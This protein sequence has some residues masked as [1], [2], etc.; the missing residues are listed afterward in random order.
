M[1]I[2][3]ANWKMNG[4]ERLCD[5]IID[6]S[7]NR[8]NKSAIVVCPPSPLLFKFN[9]CNFSLGAQNCGHKASGAFT[10]EIS[11]QL[12]RTIGCSHVILGHSERR[13]L[14]GETDERIFE[15][16]LAAIAAN[17]TPIICIGENSQEDYRV[18]LNNQISKFLSDQN[19]SQAIF[20]YEPIWSIGTGVIPSIEKISE[21]TSFVKNLTGTKVIYGGSVNDENISEILKISSLDGVLVGGASLK[22]KEFASMIEKLSTK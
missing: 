11:P 8:W 20:A 14:F 21:V 19:I 13:Q 17:L 2:I 3:V 7:K 4:D 15:K 22:P 12:L 1:K 9:A 6:I 18:V 10:G 16:Y 5:E